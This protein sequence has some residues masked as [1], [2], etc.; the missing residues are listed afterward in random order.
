MRVIKR[1]K[2]DVRLTTNEY[3]ILLRLYYAL[4]DKGFCP[5]I[6]RADQP[7]LTKLHKY[8]E[9]LPRPPQED[10]LRAEIVQIEDRWYLEITG[11]EKVVRDIPDQLKEGSWFD[12]AIPVGSSLAI[13][14]CPLG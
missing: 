12:G 5:E 4:G 13:I 6:N 10:R 7:D 14:R 1:A 2:L 11:T 8:L 3:D 9:F